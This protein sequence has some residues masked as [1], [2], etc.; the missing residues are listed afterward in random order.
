MTVTNMRDIDLP[1]STC[2]SPDVR[3]PHMSALVLLR[4]LSRCQ[5]PKGKR[6]E[7]RAWDPVVAERDMERVRRERQRSAS[8]G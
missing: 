7:P 5:A 2:I 6:P 1:G 4:V 8:E 3:G